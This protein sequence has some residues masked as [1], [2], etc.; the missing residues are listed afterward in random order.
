MHVTASTKL[1]S[2]EWVNIFSTEPLD[3]MLKRIGWG[4]RFY[5]QKTK[6]KHSK[7]KRQTNSASELGPVTGKCYVC[8]WTAKKG[9]RLCPECEFYY[10]KKSRKIPA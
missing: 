9:K 8:G 3:V 6:K 7:H 4:L 10:R 1:T 2:R 5:E